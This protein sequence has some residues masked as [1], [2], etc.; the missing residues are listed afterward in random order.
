MN[1]VHLIGRIANDLELRYTNGGTACTS[2][3]LA[4]DKGKDKDG[5]DLGA[6]FPRVT[7]FGKQAENVCK[8]L[9]KGRQIGVAGRLETGSYEK[10]GQTHYTTDVI[11][12]RVEFLGSKDQ[13]QSTQHANN[14]DDVPDGFMAVED[15]DLPF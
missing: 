3:A 9:A 8:Y 15:N 6:D 2:F 4:I 7:V 1:A 5:N 14:H 12:Q 10:D 11:A 13:G